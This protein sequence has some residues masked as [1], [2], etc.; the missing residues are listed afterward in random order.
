MSDAVLDATGSVVCNSAGVLKAWRAYAEKLG[1]AD[2]VGDAYVDTGDSGRAKPQK[3]FGRAFASAL[4]PLLI[5]R[6]LITC[7]AVSFAK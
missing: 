2:P 3:Q 1:R 4:E 7:R 6:S 5:V